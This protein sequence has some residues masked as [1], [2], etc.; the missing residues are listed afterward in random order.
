MQAFINEEKFPANMAFAAYLIKTLVRVGANTE[1][2]AISIPI[3]P[4]LANPSIERANKY[5]FTSYLWVSLG[6]LSHPLFNMHINA[7]LISKYW[8]CLNLLSKYLIS[9]YW[10]HKA[11]VAITIDL[12]Y[13]EK[14]VQIKSKSIY[15]YCLFVCFLPYIPD[16]GQFVGQRQRA[17]SI[18]WQSTIGGDTIAECDDC[19]EFSVGHK[20]VHKHLEA[21]KFRHGFAVF[22][23]DTH[24]KSK[25]PKQIL[26]HRL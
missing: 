14:N 17:I 8:S 13:I 22:W 4:K 5:I 18:Q 25:R 7:N 16:H 11:Y 9:W 10:P 3:V 15:S 20:F 2:V 6:Q 26:Q 12:S 19:A 24:Q 23:L 1:S 21:D